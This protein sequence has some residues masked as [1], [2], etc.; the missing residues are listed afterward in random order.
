MASQRPQVNYESSSNNILANFSHYPILPSL[1]RT[2]PITV[3]TYCCLTVLLRK[4]NVTLLFITNVLFSKLCSFFL[5]ESPVGKLIMSTQKSISG[6]QKFYTVLFPFLCITVSNHL[7]KP[8]LSVLAFILN[9]LTCF[10]LCPLRLWFSFVLRNENR[11][12]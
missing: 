1:S 6:W 7:A 11:V 12:T 2:L 5:H 9:F 10:H 4:Q 8:G 3:P